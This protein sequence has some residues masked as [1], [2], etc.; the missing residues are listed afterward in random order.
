[1]VNRRGRPKEML[2]GNGG[3]F[4]RGNN[5]LSDLV[6]EL[7]Q[8]KIPK[9]TA[10]QGIK[11]KFNPPRASHFGGAHEIMIKGAKRAVYAILG[12][13]DITD[14]ELR[15]APRKYRLNLEIAKK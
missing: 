2:S 1:M 14:E 6:K 4:V 7:D 5:D 8:E 13:A 10:N 12:N 9:S 11:W 15:A 3:S